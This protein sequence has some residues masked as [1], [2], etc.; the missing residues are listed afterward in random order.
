MG[1]GVI[2]I[3]GEVFKTES[4][5]EFDNFVDALSKYIENDMIPNGDEDIKIIY[6][7]YEITIKKS[8]ENELP[9]KEA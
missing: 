8:A 4:S 3:G 2:A 1:K 5:D 6:S 7:G 9:S